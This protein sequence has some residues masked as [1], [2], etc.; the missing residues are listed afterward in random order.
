MN[1]FRLQYVLGNLIPRLEVDLGLELCVHQRDFIPGQN[2]VDNIVHCVQNSKKVMMLFSTNFAK[3]HWCQFEL[4]LCLSHVMENDDM[5]EDIPSRDLAPAMM[6]VMKT[7][8]YIEWFNHDDARA[9]FW[10]RLL[11]A[12]TEIMT[13][14]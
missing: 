9:S 12:L 8:T 3:S 10:G 6:A 13:S 2:I 5:L 4:N 14:E 7:T 11:I 1:D